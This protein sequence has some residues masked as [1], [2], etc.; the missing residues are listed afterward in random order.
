MR[1]VGL[2]YARR[3][4]RLGGNQLRLADLAAEAGSY[5]SICVA[6]KNQHADVREWLEHHALLGAGTIYLWV[7]RCVC[8]KTAAV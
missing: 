1:Q 7:R 2:A 3:R 5:F 6:A 8:G 4:Q